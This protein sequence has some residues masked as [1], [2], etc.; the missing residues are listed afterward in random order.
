MLPPFFS[1][2]VIIFAGV[3]AALISI[4]VS[5]FAAD[6][7]MI[8]VRPNH[9]SSHNQVTSQAGGIAVFAGWAV[10]GVLVSALVAGDESVV[11]A[12]RLAL[13]AGLALALGYA[14]DQWD[15]PAALKF[16]GQLGIAVLFVLMF[17]PIV[18]MPLPFFG[19]TNLGPSG[20][21]ISIFWI[22]GFMNAFNFMDGANGLASGCAMI[23]LVVLALVNGFVGATFLSVA[24]FLLAASLLGFFP[25][26]Y[27]RGD[28]FMGDSGS[29]SISF[30]IAA[31]ALVSAKTHSVSFLLAPTVFLPLIFDVAF[32]LAHRIRRGKNVAIAHR[33]HLYQ[34]MIRQGRTHRDIALLYIGLTALVSAA[35]ICM[36]IMAPAQ[37][38]S[39]PAVIGAIFLVIGMRVFRSAMRA[40]LFA[41]KERAS[42]RPMAQEVRVTEVSTS[43]ASASE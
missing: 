22:V 19:Q 27:A 18:E 39:V 35:A 20:I 31:I 5:R 6:A 25:R 7:K 33:E 11:S 40:G 38:W 4:V 2:L 29:Q 28:I 17:G 15:I 37:Q 14:D 34:L 12:A 42:L 24:A 3:V 23:G 9:R 8:P 41:D 26:N 32:T 21:V 30:L 36:L 1:P 43:S 16:S 10:A 13:L